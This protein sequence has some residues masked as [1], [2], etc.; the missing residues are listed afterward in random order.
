MSEIQTLS[1]KKTQLFWG[2]S[3][4]FLTNV[5]LAEVIGPKIFSVDKTFNIA[6][7]SGWFKLDLS[8]GILIWPVV[9]LTTDII[10][11]YFGVQGVKKIT[12]IT[13]ALL[14]FVFLMFRLSTILSPAEFWMQVNSKDANGNLFDPNHAFAFNINQG[15]NIIIGSLSAFLVSQLL[16]ALVYQ[17]IR[18]MTREKHLWLRA[19]GSTFFSQLVDS[20]FILFVA[21]YFLGN[22][23]LENIFKVGTTQFIFKFLVAIISTPIVYLAHSLIDKYLKGKTTSITA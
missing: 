15:S 18:K 16:D 12:F 21:F 9:F 7:S 11:Q 13:F 10:N 3:M 5:I 4:F 8:A 14:V 2:L 20:Y 23:S 6:L 19:T 1:E 17:K 22:W